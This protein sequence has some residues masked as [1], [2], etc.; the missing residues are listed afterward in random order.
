MSHVCFSLEISVYLLV[1]HGI[2]LDIIT[3]CYP[4]ADSFEDNFAHII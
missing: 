2:L 4:T 3:S 1:L